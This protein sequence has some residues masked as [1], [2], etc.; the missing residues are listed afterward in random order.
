MM[1][2]YTHFNERHH[3]VS[4]H[5]LNQ[6]F[7]YPTFKKSYFG[8]WDTRHFVDTLKRLPNSNQYFSF[9][10]WHNS[11]PTSQQGYYL[12]HY[13]NPNAINCNLGFATLPTV[14]R[15]QINEG[16]L[17]LLVVFV[18]ETFDRTHSINE[19]Q[20]MF[21][22]QLTEM[23]I[24]RKKSVKVLV[25]GHSENMMKHLDDR[26]SWIF[27]PWFEAA[28]QADAYQNAHVLKNVDV[29]DHKSQK[30]YKFL[31][32]NRAPRAHRAILLAMLEYMQ[33]STRG[34]VTWPS[35]DRLLTNVPHSHSFRMGIKRDHNFEKFLLTNSR[36]SDQYI[37][38]RTEPAHSWL[39]AVPLYQQAEFE[40]VNETHHYNIGDI[41]FLTE[42]TFRSLMVGIPFLLHGNPRSLK[43]LHQL[44]YKTFDSV[45]DESYDE[46]YSPMASL[47]SIAN[48]VHKISSIMDWDQNPVHQQEVIDVAKHNKKVFWEKPH[49]NNIWNAIS[50]S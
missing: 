4:T 42:K 18:Y 38:S 8:G 26:V 41:V 22:S 32:L 11:I 37:D 48:Q 45:F 1:R 40:I 19:W 24:H 13:G 33:I 31:S 17:H 25:S 28:L 3:P 46:I 5:E 7:L 39:T 15:D 50:N 16:D 47:T 12:L 27:Y 44:G 29:Y 14:V 35:D 49:A 20:N 21:C 2:I 36:L 34:Y 10:E 43:L 9:H 23:G 30:K 6:D